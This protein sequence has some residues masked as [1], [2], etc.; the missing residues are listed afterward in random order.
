MKY[1]CK[2]TRTDI[3]E[4]YYLVVTTMTRTLEDGS[5]EIKP[6]EQ[7][8]YLYEDEHRMKLLETGIFP[9]PFIE[10]NKDRNGSAIRWNYGLLA[11]ILGADCETDGYVQNLNLSD[12]SK[13]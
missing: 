2:I 9:R 13:R 6:D 1:Q 11:E 10:G 4:V 3:D 5:I 8:W 7:A 12:G